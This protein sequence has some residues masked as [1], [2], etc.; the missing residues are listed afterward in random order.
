MAA[1]SCRVD[2][3]AALLSCVLPPRERGPSPLW[4]AA[5][6]AREIEPPPLPGGRPSLTP[7]AECPERGASVSVSIS[8]SI[9][10]AAG[11]TASLPVSAVLGGLGCGLS[12]DG[13]LRHTGQE[14][15]AVR[16]HLMMQSPWKL[17]PQASVMQAAPRVACASIGLRQMGQSVEGAAD[18]TAGEAESS[19]GE[20]SD[21]PGEAVEAAGA[22]E[23]PAGLKPAG[24][25][26]LGDAT[27]AEEAPVAAGAEEDGAAAGRLKKKSI[28]G[29]AAVSA[30]LR[31][32][33]DRCA[34]FLPAATPLSG[35]S[36]S[37]DPDS[38]SSS[39][40]ASSSNSDSAQH[41][42]IMMS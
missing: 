37:P 19:A 36:S 12:A 1:R 32:A 23:E 17:W 21:C 20:A 41:T 5:L 4:L 16:S 35:A 9:V 11:V 10:A 33:E 13:P 24:E 6:S 15:W 28:R 29:R 30:A 27:S 14:V 8:V 18:P 34:R 25:P 22:A 3:R 26:R 31:D 38:T 40:T 7:L 39:A 42:H 2:P